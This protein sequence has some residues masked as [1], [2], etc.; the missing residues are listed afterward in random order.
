MVTTTAIYSGEQ[1][2]ISR[3]L[4]GGASFGHSSNHE[5]SAGGKLR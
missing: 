4:L 2:G 1:L 3:T 5:A